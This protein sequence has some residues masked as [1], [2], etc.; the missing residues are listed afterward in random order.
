MRIARLLIRTVPV[1]VLA[2]LAA[3]VLA[4]SAPATGSANINQ[5]ISIAKLTDLQFGALV[6]PASGFG[7]VAIDALSGTR[8]VGGNAGA[9]GGATGRASF[10]V[11]GDPN[12]AFSA[13]VPVSFSLDDETPG[14]D[15]IVVLSSDAPPLLDGS[16]AAVIGVGGQFPLTPGQKLGAYT[17]NFTISVAYN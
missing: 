7:S 6:R 17:G 16:G 11:T 9:A 2:G 1:L 10:N 12:R 3:P 15:I 5:A 14:N 4:R 8:L 13:T